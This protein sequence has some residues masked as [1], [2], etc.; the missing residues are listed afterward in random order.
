M[1]KE[2]GSLTINKQVEYYHKAAEEGSIPDEQNPVS[3]VQ[4]F[5]NE[6][7]LK[8]ALEQLDIR[9]FATHELK[10]R[11]L[12]K[13]CKWVGFSKAEAIWEKTKQTTTRNKKSLRRL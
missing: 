8:I 2:K 7:L 3:I 11:G 1:A 12:N 10:S 9:P 4:T 5:P 13:E 6:L